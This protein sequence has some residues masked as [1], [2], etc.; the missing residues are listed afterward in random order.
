MGFPHR[1]F[2]RRRNV[3]ANRTLLSLMR[4]IET[5][6]MTYPNSETMLLVDRSK[7]N[8]ATYDF[9]KFLSSRK[10][11]FWPL[12]LRYQQNHALWKSA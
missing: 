11:F 3:I 5:L 9:E 8:D 6:M 1:L 7:E 12:L 2:H 10:Y 4:S